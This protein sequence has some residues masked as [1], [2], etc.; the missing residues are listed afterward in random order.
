MGIHFFAQT[1]F[2]LT[3]SV[4]IIVVGVLMAIVAYRLIS[5]MRHLDNISQSLDDST[6]EFK[7]RFIGMLEKLEE[8]P[9]LSYLFKRKTKDEEEEKPRRRNVRLKK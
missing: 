1:I 9:F 7:S 2:Y 5:I 8:L 3:T 6:Y 4:A